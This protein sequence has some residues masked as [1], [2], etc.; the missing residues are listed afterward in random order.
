MRKPAFC[1]CENKD[2]DQLCGYREDSYPH[3]SRAD[4][5]RYR[6]DSHAGKNPYRHDRR[7]DSLSLQK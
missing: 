6:L 4:K 2:A 1:L 7:A 3:N 5:G